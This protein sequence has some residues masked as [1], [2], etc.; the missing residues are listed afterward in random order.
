MAPLFLWPTSGL[1]Q[2]YALP[3]SA[4][5][6]VWR[7][8]VWALEQCQCPNAASKQKAVQGPRPGR[9]TGKTIAGNPTPTGINQLAIEAQ[10]SVSRQCLE[11]SVVAFYLVATCAGTSNAVLFVH[12]GL[13][14]PPTIPAKFNRAISMTFPTYSYGRKVANRDSPIPL[15]LQ[16]QQQCDRN[17]QLHQEVP[18]R[19]QSLH[20]GHAAV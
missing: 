5:P 16:V 8:W 4:S 9:Y 12:A 13:P 11:L 17:P 2:R 10:R 15:E 1:A 7:S 14:K 18:E 19:R 3:L 6:G 20:D